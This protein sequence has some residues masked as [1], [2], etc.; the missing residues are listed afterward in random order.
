[1]SNYKLSNEAKNDL[2]RIHQFGVAQF[3]EVQ[4][5]KSDKCLMILGL[6]FF[7]YFCNIK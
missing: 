7:L 2:I 3:G 1:M 4:A 5:D 6:I